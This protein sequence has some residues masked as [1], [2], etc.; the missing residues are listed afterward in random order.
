M[1][2]AAKTY[3]TPHGWVMG[4]PEIPGALWYGT[5]EGAMGD[6]HEV[7]IVEVEEGTGEL[8]CAG[9]TFFGWRLPSQVTCGPERV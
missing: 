7:A 6:I 5:V 1:N 9:P 2:K 8:L 3:Q 4:L